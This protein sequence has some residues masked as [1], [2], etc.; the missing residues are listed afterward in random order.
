MQELDVMA[1]TKSRDF[2]VRAALEAFSCADRIQQQSL[3]LGRSVGVW[4]G[5]AAAYADAGDHASALGDLERASA[6]T[7]NR[8]KVWSVS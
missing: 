7:R 4:L 5:R 1:K 6:H 8:S 3:S 2:H